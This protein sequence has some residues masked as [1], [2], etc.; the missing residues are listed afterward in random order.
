[1]QFDHPVAD[2]KNNG[3]NNHSVEALNHYLLVNC[4]GKHSYNLPF[5]S[6]NLYGRDDFYLQ[7]V[8]NGI[9]ETHIDGKKYDMQPGDV[10][11]Y[12]PKT[13][14]YYTTKTPN[15]LV[16]Y[17]VHF[18]GSGALPLTQRCG[19]N[20]KTVMH[21]GMD[22]ALIS[23]FHAVF[24]DYVEHDFLFVD[25]GAAHLMDVLIRIGRLIAPE[26]TAGNRAQIAE[27]LRYIHSNFNREISTSQLSEMEHL[28]PSHYRTVFRKC[29]GV[30]PLEYIIRLRINHA[31]ELLSQQNMAV[32]Q[33]AEMVG[34]RDPLYFSRIFRERIGVMPSGYRLQAI[35]QATKSIDK[36]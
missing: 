13:E 29:T 36:E 23:G 31:C 5:V 33:V 16:Y 15:E 35:E 3:L 2:S 18:T 11:L 8:V 14:Y 34:Y 26:G 20:N 1:V 25:A 24:N 12:A 17:W 22:D 19:L 28:S 32:R 9:L 27:S 30:S 21:P 6:H 4:A 7:Y 10:V